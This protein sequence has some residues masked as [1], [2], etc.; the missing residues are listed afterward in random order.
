MYIDK[1]RQ[2]IETTNAIDEKLKKNRSISI[3]T[4]YENKNSEHLKIKPKESGM[5]SAQY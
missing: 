1:P 5:T 2:K 3:F 4:P